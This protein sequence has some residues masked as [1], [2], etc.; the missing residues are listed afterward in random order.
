MF[1]IEIKGREMER[2]L[3][4]KWNGKAA[5]LRKNFAWNEP[6]EKGD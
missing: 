1:A 2:L 5:P 4:E 3:L 6:Y